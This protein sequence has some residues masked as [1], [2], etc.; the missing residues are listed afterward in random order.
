MFHLYLFHDT[1]GAPA[2]RVII[3]RYE[4]I[5]RRPESYSPGYVKHVELAA[6]DLRD[7]KVQARNFA[8]RVFFGGKE[9]R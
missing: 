8:P 2:T 1:L 5:E 4:S 6:R 7:A 3:S 9:V